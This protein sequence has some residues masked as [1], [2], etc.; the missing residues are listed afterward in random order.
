M[1]DN[2]NI[3]NNA[4]KGGTTFGGTHESGN[5]IKMQVVGGEN[6]KLEGGEG[7]LSR[8]TMKDNTKIPFNGKMATPCEIASELNVKNGGNAMNC[9]NELQNDVD[10]IPSKYR[11]KAFKDGGN[12]VSK[13]KTG[14]NPI[15]SINIPAHYQK[16]NFDLQGHKFD[17]TKAYNLIKNGEIK[18]ELLEAS[19]KELNSKVTYIDESKAESIKNDYSKPLGLIIRIKGTR[20]KHLLIDG[21]HRTYKAMLDNK[22]KVYY[23]YIKNANDIHKFYST[24]NDLKWYEDGGDVSN[25]GYKE[26]LQKLKKEL[27]NEVFS[28]G[29]YIIEDILK[30]AEIPYSI[31]KS[32]KWG[33]EYWSICGLRYR[34][35]DHD[36]PNPE[37]YN[38]EGDYYHHEELLD[39]LIN[40]KL[41]L[42]DKTKTKEEFIKNA[43]NLLKKNDEKL[44][45]YYCSKDD[46]SPVFYDKTEAEKWCKK[47]GKT[48]NVYKKEEDI[49]ITPDGAKF[50]DEQSATNYIW[51][52]NK[53]NRGCGNY[54]Q[55]GSIAKKFYITNK[56]HAKEY[57]IIAEKP[58]YIQ[59]INILD[60]DMKGEGSNALKEIEQYAKDNNC[61]VVFGHISQKAKF[62]GDIKDC[63]F[64]TDVDKIKKWFIDKGYA[65]NQETNDFH[66]VLNMEYEDGGNIPRKTTIQDVNT[67]IDLIEDDNDITMGK[68]G[69]ITE[70][71]QAIIN[72]IDEILAK[73]NKPINTKDYIERAL[74]EKQATK[75]FK[76]IGTRVG[77]SKKEQAVMRNLLNADDIIKYSGDIPTAFKLA[78]KK[79]IL[80]EYNI[81]E[82]KENGVES[83]AAYLKYHIYKSLPAKTKHKDFSRI[84][85]YV[86]MLN[87]IKDGLGTCT[88]LEQV[89]LF[90][91]KVESWNATD[92]AD[93]L[94]LY[95]GLTDENKEKMLNEI[96]GKLKYYGYTRKILKDLLGVRFYNVFFG[97][98]SGGVIHAEARKFNGKTK[99]EVDEIKAKQLKSANIRIERTNKAIWDIEKYDAEDIKVNRFYKLSE[100]AQINEAWLKHNMK[101]LAYNDK[102]KLKENILEVLKNRVT[103]DQK[104]IQSWNI[105]TESIPPDWKWT[106]EILKPK[107]VGEKK[108]NKSTL[109]KINTGVPLDYIK[110][111][112]GYK[113]EESDIIPN[114][115]IDK[116][117]FKSVQFGNYVKDNEAKEHIKHFMSAM[118]D[119]S[120]ILNINFEKF[121]KLGGLSIAFGARGSGGAAAHYE[122]GH[123]IINITKKNGDGAIAHEYGHYI[124]NLLPYLYDKTKP[125]EFA[126][127]HRGRF[128]PNTTYIDNIALRTTFIKLMKA[129]IK[130]EDGYRETVDTTFYKTMYKHDY[131]KSDLKETFEETIE[132]VKQKYAHYF[133]STSRSKNE[134]SAKFMGFILHHFN[135]D[136]VDLGITPKN[137][138]AYYSY[139]SRAGGYWLRPTELFARAFE[140]FIYDKLA[141][142][143]RANNY[144]T[145]GSWFNTVFFNKD[146]LSVKT[147]PFGKERELLYKRF[148]EFFKIFREEHNVS[149]FSWNTERV[150]EI[151][152]LK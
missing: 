91:K 37:N 2:Y 46:D 7:V 45:K 109:P 137:A 73:I 148:D 63:D 115:L 79:D 66:K 114:V 28:N 76:D 140:M 116:Y 100:I 33:S 69:D 103:K 149:G 58:L 92:I 106:D 128:S 81:E 16:E 145:S 30:N 94:Y 99:T 82:E 27:R 8:N 47:W 143:N 3:T 107:T 23:Y 88:T 32:H 49:F 44:V 14:D 124:D 122:S 10:K 87:Y 144:L 119:I 65:V 120:D 67:R 31:K 72:K 24:D 75:S 132:Y 35:A 15:T 147:Y 135:I 141:N 19:P 39:D 129:M 21:N 110:R 41:D 150:D 55:G 68:G 104:L 113:I 5:D 78:K 130:G 54:Q 6:V 17:I 131:S 134:T 1:A 74:D 70:S 96:S 40:K 142:L 121:N 127:G 83:G 125:L 71:E 152:D 11:N 98:G 22:D 126:S 61:D 38:F 26:Y 60:V 9:S 146:G 138:S 34:I 56:E 77:G 101:Y 4:A 62:Y 151:I 13:K 43:K 102:E 97:Y 53:K 52:K 25:D 111:I 51:R 84:Y 108:E 12:I 85:G 139:A 90:I 48:H 112:G 18:A 59:S 95:D 123:K 86:F 50:S 117:G 42:S 57:G 93:L 20:D 89:D 133:T 64:C 29:R 105:E 136:K 36:K 118:I 80:P